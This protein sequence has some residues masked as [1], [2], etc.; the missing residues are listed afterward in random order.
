MGEQKEWSF[1]IWEERKGLLGAAA[2]EYP[3]PFAALDRYLKAVP[4]RHVETL[5]TVIYTLLDLEELK[6]FL[7]PQPKPMGAITGLVA[8]MALEHWSRESWPPG[9]V[10][11]EKWKVWAFPL[12]ASTF[13]AS[14][15]PSEGEAALARSLIGTF[16]FQ[17]EGWFDPNTPREA[18][19][20]LEEPPEPLEPLLGESLQGY[21]KRAEAHYRAFKKWQEGYEGEVA[22]TWATRKRNLLFLAW[23]EVEGLTEE[24]IAHRV[25]ERIRTGH[26]TAR[27]LFE[28]RKAEPLGED[29]TGS[30]PELIH[31]A[32][33]LTRKRLRIT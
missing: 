9:K 31:K 1:L 15:A 21:L 28:G 19:M 17:I 13:I 3:E 25:E 18:G 32:I 29:R 20:P 12:L 30:L 23:R 33:V 4:R 11:P 10:F 26:R 16:L 5:G 6:R 24:E 7:P 2:L 27:Y 8:W 22:Q 14:E